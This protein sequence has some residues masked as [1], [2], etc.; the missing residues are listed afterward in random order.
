MTDLA[1]KIDKVQLDF[2][3]RRNYRRKRAREEHD[4]NAP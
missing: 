2:R 1:E 4:R 3:Q